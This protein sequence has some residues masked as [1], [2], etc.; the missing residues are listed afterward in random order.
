MTERFAPRPCAETEWTRR[1]ERDI[2]AKRWLEHGGKFY[3]IGTQV[4]DMKPRLPPSSAANWQRVNYTGQ[5]F[6]TLKVL[7][8]FGRDEF[9]R[10][11]WLVRC[12]VCGAER[13]LRSDVLRAANTSPP[14]CCE[15]ALPA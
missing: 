15:R 1:W 6:G 5:M 14:G 8:R 2:R 11:M 9:G 3:P 4:A 12:T 7:Y 10:A 13:Q